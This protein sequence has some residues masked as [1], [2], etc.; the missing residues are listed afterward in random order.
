MGRVQILG[1]SVGL[2]VLGMDL[3]SIVEGREGCPFSVWNF[4]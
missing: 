4:L 2:Q 1:K 3:A